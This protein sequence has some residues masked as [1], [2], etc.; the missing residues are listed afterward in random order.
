MKTSQKPEGNVKDFVMQL[1]SYK[2]IIDARI[3]EY[4]PLI[5]SQISEQFGEYPSEAFKPF[6]SYMMRG[7]KRI[8]GALTMLGYEMF[9]GTNRKMILDAAMAIEMLQSYLL[10]MDDI[11]DRSET[12]R[13]GPTAHVMLTK[14]H[15]DNYLK[16]DAAHF[17]ESIALDSY[18][19]GCHAAFE[20]IA[21][22]DVEPS[23]LLRAM[24]NIHKCYV[25]TAHGQTVDIFS[26]VVDKVTEDDVNNVLIWKTAFYTFIN[27]LQFG[28]ILAGAKE[29][30]LKMLYNYGLPAGKAFQ[31]TDDILGIYG[32]EFES[33]KSPMDDIRDGKKTILIVKALELAER[34]E[35]YYLK[36]CLGKRDLSMGEFSECKKIISNCGAKEYAENLARE[37][38]EEALIALSINTENC[39]KKYTAFLEGLVNYLLER[40]S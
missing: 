36:Q 6:A 21:E 19:V 4:L 32:N 16:G 24:R 27:P 14:Y 8:R 37:S 28:A 38:V 3:E 23:T 31:I 33:G 10:I 9:G 2:N 5:E 22:L 29:T 40:K 11:Q 25:T 7:G 35:A 15:K 18:L 39:I 12:R 26:E 30:D 13:G 20:L 17:G 1:N 34:S